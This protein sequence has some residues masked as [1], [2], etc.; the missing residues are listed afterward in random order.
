MNGSSASPA[1]SNSPASVTSAHEVYFEKQSAPQTCVLHSLNNA[2]GFQMATEKEFHEKALEMG[3]EYA[4]IAS[5]RSKKSFETL[6][7]AYVEALYTKENGWS[8]DVARRILRDRGIPSHSV[9]KVEQSGKYLVM[10]P[11]HA[12]AIRDG[13]ILDSLRDRPMR[14]M[15]GDVMLIFKID[16]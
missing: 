10:R 5:K 14:N 13:L 7:N 16:L 2:M 1:S 8:L 4:L 9:T 6:R 12:I 3:S 15:P 11:Q